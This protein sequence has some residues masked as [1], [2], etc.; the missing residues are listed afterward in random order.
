MPGYDKYIMTQ[1]S[2]LLLLL[3]PGMAHAQPDLY[4]ENLGIEDGL[5]DLKVMSILQD[6]KGFM[7]IG[8]EMGGVS[9]YDGQKMTT[10]NYDPDFPERSYPGRCINA[11][12]EDEEGYIWATG[13]PPSGLLKFDPEKEAIAAHYPIEGWSATAHLGSNGRIWVGHSTEGLLFLDKASGEVR[14]FVEEFAPEMQKE[15]VRQILEDSSG[16]LWFAYPNGI[17]Q[18]IEADNN[19]IYH[20]FREPLDRTIDDNLFSA[21]IEDSRHTIWVGTTEGLFYYDAEEKEFQA[22]ALPYPIHSITAL[23][24]DKNGDLWIGHTEGLFILNTQDRSGKQYSS[25]SGREGALRG[26]PNTIYK[27]PQGNMWLGQFAEGVFYWNQHRKKFSTYQYDPNILGSIGWNTV[28]GLHEDKDGGIWVAC[29]Q[30]EL[31][32]PKAE[33]FVPVFQFNHD[34]QV[35]DVTEDRQNRLWIG[36]WLKGIQLLSTTGQTLARFQ[37]DPTNRDSLPGNAAIAI[38]ADRLGNIWVAVFHEGLFLYQPGS[39]SFKKYPL[40]HPETHVPIGTGIKT[41]HEDQKG[42]LWLGEN[43]RLIKLTPDYKVEQVLDISTLQI[44]EDPTGIFWIASIDGLYR[45]DPASGQHRVWRQ[46][47]GLPVNDVHSILVDDHGNFWL[48]T[49]KGLAYFDRRTEAITVYDKSD[50]LPG[51]QF[52]TAASLKTSSGEFYF[53][54]REGLLRFQPDSI[55][56]NPEVPP[57]VITDF[58]IRNV[59]VPIQGAEKDT[60]DFSSPLEKHIAYLDELRLGW[61][62]ND[63]A[64]T[65]AALNFLKPEK[66]QYKYRLHNY[67]EEWTLTDGKN[68]NAVYTNLDPGQYTFQVLGSNNDGE[69]NE[70]GVSLSIIILPPWWAT[71]WA[72]SLYA[73]LLLAGLYT[74]RAYELNRKMAHHEAGRLRELDGIKSRLYTNI[75]HEFRTPLSIIL[76]VAGQLK[77]EVQNKTAAHLDMIERNGRQLL[78]LVNQ[79]LDLSKIES[80]KLELNYVQSDI[81]NFLKYL[82]ESFHS[83]AEQK[84]IQLHFLSDLD[85]LIMD[86]DPER[87]Q[88]IFYNLLS[89]ALKFTPEGGNVYFQLSQLNDEQLELK[90]KDTGI[91]MAEDQLSKIFERFYQ[92]D[93][94][95]T[96]RAEGTGIGLALVRDLLQ[97]MGGT[98]TVKSKLGRGTEFVLTL[99]IHHHA[100]IS[101]RTEM[102]SPLPVNGSTGVRPSVAS[103]VVEG[104]RVLVIEDNPDVRFYIRNCLASGYRIEMA[105]DGEDGIQKAQKIIPDLIM[106]D[107]MMPLKDGFEVCAILKQDRR[108]SHIPIVML[109]AKADFQSR[110]EGLQH[111]ADLYLAKPFQEEELLL[112]LHNLLLQRD[113]LQQHYLFISGLVAQA[114]PDQKGVDPETQFVENVKSRILE[115]L[116]DSNFTI[117]QLS[118]EMALSQS[119][120]HRKL[121]ALTG[122]SA[123]KMV[124]MIRLHHATQLLQDQSLT[125]SAV[126]YDCGFND[127]DYMSKL[128]KQEFGLTP[129]EFRSGLGTVKKT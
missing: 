125:V 112:H 50:G 77:K 121:T 60:A 37:A 85:S 71:W 13:G 105:F 26:A 81:V 70:M 84:A 80:G 47:D 82:T 3:V 35:W 2:I 14:S 115:H 73:I 89:N 107:V 101:T 12:F 19:L 51:Y 109:T 16:N 87:L 78:H 31:F 102:P 34:H 21:L 117:S 32:D 49:K 69:W 124:R 98:I 9:R 46:K 83:L 56:P 58:K 64:F 127:P 68:P 40:F 18:W 104:P 28:T 43:Y 4:F 106:C 128:F 72:Y 123:S 63:I 48:G 30:L 67:E 61:R 7:W 62:Q 93:D 27:D 65:F 53:G 45:F 100:A 25:N 33:T 91:G 1:L 96:R 54:L 120:L 129:T 55:R 10:F 23:E 8:T 38:Y 114:D 22:Y 86:Y 29:G 122:F 95:D 111:G 5:G 44:Y 108:T 116:S 75:T 76:G 126:A 15:Y 99:P 6:R 92:L 17:Y 113:R 119:Q 110:I 118:R 97:L 42:N 36:S 66:N 11:M 24:E 103:L 39:Q 74:I 79:L 59:S 94:S 52:S 90:V 57:V 20:P 88:Q 41:F